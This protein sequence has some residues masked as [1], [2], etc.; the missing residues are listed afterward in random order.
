[1]ENK[2]IYLTQFDFER[3]NKLIIEAQSTDYRKSEYLEKLRAEIARAVIVTPQDIPGDVITMNSIVCLKDVETGEEETYTLVFPEDAN[4]Q[5]G[6]LSVLAPIGTAMLG[7][8]V[9]DFFEWDVPAG[10]R[11]L[12]ITKI[13]YQPEASGDFDR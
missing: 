11:R 7:Y 10:K 4:L 6:K 13:L 1:M 2:P 8:Q 3:L 9:G 5:H 12:Q